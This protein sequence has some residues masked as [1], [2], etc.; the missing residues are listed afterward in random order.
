MPEGWI[1]RARVERSGFFSP[2]QAWLERGP[3]TTEGLARLGDWFGLGDGAREAWLAAGEGIAATLETIH[4]PRDGQDVGGWTFGGAHRFD[5]AL[6]ALWMQYSVARAERLR[7]A[8][9]EL[10]ALALS[11]CP[12]E[13][14]ARR[15]RLAAAA[16]RIDA[17]LIPL[18]GALDRYRVDDRGESTLPL[19]ILDRWTSHPAGEP[20]CCD[21][22]LA[23]VEPFV[24]RLH[25]AAL[26]RAAA[27]EH[28][29]RAMIATRDA[30]MW[31]RDAPAAA[32][33][34][35]MEEI[36]RRIEAIDGVARQ[37]FIA[38]QEALARI[39]DATPGCGPDAV[40][41]WR[42]GAMPAVERL[43]PEARVRLAERPI[44]SASEAAV[45]AW[46]LAEEDAM[47][48]AARDLAE[49]AGILS[50]TDPPARARIDEALESLQARRGERSQRALIRLEI[51]ERSKAPDVAAQ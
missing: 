26:A 3:L 28:E 20:G 2:A 13:T 49:S 18:H 36:A 19:A 42:A 47:L 8:E 31:L 41:H 43:A 24:D 40:R 4:R 15:V 51:L 23:A 12:D 7:G 32:A 39:L 21:E 33:Q 22:V 29:V 27:V 30:A 35:R 45:L 5:P 16:L 10:F 37:G 46:Y 38:E 14:S 44:E 11:L 1:V 6:A 50:L 48:A 25:S 9:E 34:G 17:A